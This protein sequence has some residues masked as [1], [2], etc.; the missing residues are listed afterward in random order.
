MARGADPA[1]RSDHDRRELKMRAE[2]QLGHDVDLV[3]F[4]R[5][6]AAAA[7][8]GIAVSRGDRVGLRVVDDTLDD[9]GRLLLATIEA[10]RKAEAEEPGAA[11]RMMS[12][13]FT[14]A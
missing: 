5:L 12:A 7:E 8:L 4:V 13:A 6:S 3:T 11:A 10:A 9:R 14:E 2:F 1:W